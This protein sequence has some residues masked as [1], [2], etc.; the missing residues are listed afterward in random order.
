VRL[1]L[2]TFYPLVSVGGF[3]VV[4]DYGH[5]VGAQRA[6]DEYRT[7]VGDDDPLVPID[8]T[9]RYWRKP[10]PKGPMPVERQVWRRGL[11]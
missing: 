8:D 11:F 2:E 5:W 1:T 10:E 4:D 9:G 7:A 3:V 6:T